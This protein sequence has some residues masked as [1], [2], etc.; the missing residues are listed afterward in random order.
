MHGPF[1]KKCRFSFH[2]RHERIFRM[3]F[4][5][6]YRKC[7]LLT[8]A[9]REETYLK[10]KHAVDP[11]S[12]HFFNINVCDKLPGD[13]VIPDTRNKKCQTLNYS[14]DVPLVSIIITFH[15]E[16][17]CALFRTIKSVIDRTPSHLIKE[18]ILVDDFSENVQDGRELLKISKV[19]VL[20]NAEREGLIRSRNK[21]AANATAEVLVF[22][23]SHC[24]V[25]DQWLEPLLTR[26][27][28]VM[29]KMTSSQ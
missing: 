19:V 7:V 26:I 10:A 20:R 5:Y 11:F 3:G 29:A 21:G 14:K 2:D 15:N 23:D 27:K 28:Q 16:A 6:R 1:G 12:K 4:F 9:F 17:R 13:R 25:N 22:L 8:L 18:I 24:E